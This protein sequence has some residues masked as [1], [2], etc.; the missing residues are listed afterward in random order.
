MVTRANDPDDALTHNP[1]KPR[2]ANGAKIAGRDTITE[3]SP[4]SCNLPARHR[5]P[6]DVRASVAPSRRSDRSI[7]RRKATRVRY[8][9]SPVQARPR[10]T[11]TT[12]RCDAGGGDDAHD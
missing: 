3:R 6:R 9:V 7:E 10:A 2:V 5:L 11:Y 8:H 4:S 1:G 12:V